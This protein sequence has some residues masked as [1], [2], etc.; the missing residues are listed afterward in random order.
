M[1]PPQRQAADRSSDAPV[2]ASD[3]GAGGWG[4]TVSGGRGRSWRKW[5]A[6]A[7]A[8]VVLVPLLF[9][10]ATA[11]HAS[12]RISR[13]Q[14]SNLSPASGA[15]NILVVGS[16]SRADLTKQQQQ[17][18]TAG[19][20][21]GN[22]TDT[23]FIMT[24]HGGRVALLA[25][26]RD[27]YVTRCDGSKGRINAAME[28]DGP[29][30]LVQTVS[31]L[32]GLKISHF[33][34]VHF[35]GFTEIVNAVGGVRVCLDKAIKD[36]YAGVDLPAGCQ[37][38]DGRTALGYVRV[39]KIDSDLQRIKRQ[40]QFLHALASKI[41]S[42]GTLLNPFRLWATAGNIGGALSADEEL[43]LVDLFKMA[44]AGRG[45]ASGATVTK[46][47]PTT[48]KTIGG[49]AVLLPV[50]SE[51]EALFA[52]FRNGQILQQATSGLH[53]ADV[54]V[55]VLNGAGISGLAGQTADAL[56]QK[57]YQ[58]ADIGNAEPT[59]KTV[60][61]YPAGKED[62]AKLLAGDAPVKVQLEQSDTVDHVTLVLGKD[63]PAVSEATTRVLFVCLGN[64][65][66]SPTAAAAA[67][68][69]ADEVG[70]PLEVDSAGV[71]GWHV[72]EPP[73][74]RMAAAARAR[75]L[76]LTGTARQV[77][78]EDFDRYDLIVAMDRDNLAELERLA[79]AGPHARLVLFRD[80]EPDAAGPDVPDPYYEGG[81]DHVV[82]IVRA[83]ARGLLE[84]I[85]RGDR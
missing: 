52:Q 77:T 21:E 12:S 43:G 15:M 79:P 48:P 32:S 41:M 58:V 74:A 38:L 71:S 57:G 34:A 60:I 14:V 31:E 82:D 44:Y 80:L 84:A 19:F 81:F 42:P 8:V 56:K 62:A 85:T 37:M 27:L 64:I 61:R 72:G 18:F 40:Q 51:A 6:V 2:G 24:I 23:I 22:R 69:A 13:E 66:R 59:E 45:L 68:E 17:E 35:L 4:P 7:V 30:C 55:V 54:T 16:D 26:P 53:P 75:G 63:V 78:V 70:V 11:V 9:G 20:A 33:V 1:T 73:D 83:G 50:K 49:A 47:V 5:L 39:R 29:G 76:E 28:I 25:F 10:L 65:C 36:P 46:T 3:G 67:R